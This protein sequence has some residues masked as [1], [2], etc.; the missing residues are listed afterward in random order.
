MYE[1]VAAPNQSCT[2]SDQFLVKYV[3]KGGQTRIAGSFHES[4]K[5]NNKYNFA[6][7]FTL[8]TGLITL[9]KNG[10]VTLSHVGLTHQVTEVIVTKNQDM[11]PH[12]QGLQWL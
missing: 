9:L 8:A 6:R 4:L 12:H 2:R 1:A 7:L 10:M 5:V 11:H 3:G